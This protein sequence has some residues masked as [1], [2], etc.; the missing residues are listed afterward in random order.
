[1]TGMTDKK[2]GPIEVLSTPLA[3]T[4]AYRVRN[5]C[6][7]TE[8]SSEVQEEQIRLDVASAA[9]E[10]PDHACRLVAQLVRQ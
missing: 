9:G 4:G 6:G 5:I 2:I 7:A 3:A 10:L 8:Q 1:M